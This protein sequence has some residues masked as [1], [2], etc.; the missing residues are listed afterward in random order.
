VGEAKLKHTELIILRMFYEAW[1][2][3][4]SMPVDQPE[5]KQMACDHMVEMAHA[6]RRF[7][8]GDPPRIVTLN[9]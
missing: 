4:H 9:G 1:E 6:M 8:N 3:F 7:K 5:Q 2:T